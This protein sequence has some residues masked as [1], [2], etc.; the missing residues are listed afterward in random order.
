[1]GAAVGCVEGVEAGTSPKDT[2]RAQAYVTLTTHTANSVP[3]GTG[4]F[5]LDRNLGA[6]F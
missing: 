5:N 3:L 2:T 6:S 4:V 1:M